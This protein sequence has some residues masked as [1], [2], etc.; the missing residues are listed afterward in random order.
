MPLTTRVKDWPAT[1][2]GVAHV[3]EAAVRYFSLFPCP[4]NSIYLG[5]LDSGWIQGMRMPD[6]PSCRSSTKTM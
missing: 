1:Q 6:F 4:T 5:S 3:D 2:R